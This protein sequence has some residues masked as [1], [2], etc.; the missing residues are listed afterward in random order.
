M[1]ALLSLLLA[2]A[3]PDGSCPASFGEVVSATEA[4]YAG[5]LVK[6]PDAEAEAAYR[7]FRD[8]LG[9]R[10]AASADPAAC[11]DVLTAYVGFFADHHLFVAS[12]GVEASPLPAPSRRWTERRIATHLQRHAGQLDPVEGHWY[13]AEGPLAVLHDPGLPP[14]RFLALRPAGRAAAQPAALV[15]RH[16][17]GYRVS[18]RQPRFG[19]QTQPAALRRGGEL[20]AFGTSGWGRR[21]AGRLD[22]GDPMAPLFRDEG[23]G[24]YYLS[25]PS[26]MPAY[27]EPLAALVARHGSELAAA[28]GLLLDVRGNAGGD[29]IYFVLAPYLLANDIEIGRATS[30][31][32]S[33]RTLQHF[34]A[35][36]ERLGEQGAWLDQPLAAMQASPGAIVPFREGSRDGLPEYPALPAEVLVL[37]DRGVGSAAEAFVYHARQSRKVVTM[38]EPTRGNIDYMQ[39]S[40]HRVGAGDFRYWFGYPLYFARDLPRDSVDDSGY[41]PDVA[42]TPELGDPVAFALDWLERPAAAR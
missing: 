28:R 2:L 4:N 37:Q 17:A 36:R 14:G 22:P 35:L 9:Q 5:Y 21:G 1:P 27:R 25:M 6:L 32:A 19:W 24:R 38:G 23:D 18:H 8:L 26:F 34:T 30:V 31:R 15:E 3:A 7:R 11:R 42:L 13:D 33:P 39:V 40:M 29:A 12:D 10:A 20:L 41:P 16:G